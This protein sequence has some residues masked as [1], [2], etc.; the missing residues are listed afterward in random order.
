MLM[1]CQYVAVG[2]AIGTTWIDTMMRSCPSP[3]RLCGMLVSIDFVV[4]FT[5]LDT[6]RHLLVLVGPKM[7]LQS[8]KLWAS[9][10]A[11][12]SAAKC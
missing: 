2:L 8:R 3:L 12:G 6:C 4:V 9:E 11:C 5:T 10:R 1:A 7:N